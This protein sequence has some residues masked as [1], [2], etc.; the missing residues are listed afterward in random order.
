MKSIHLIEEK[1]I[2]RSSIKEDTWKKQKHCWVTRH[3]M[4][5]VR[6]FNA[7]PPDTYLILKITMVDESFFLSLSTADGWGFG[8]FLFVWMQ[9][10][11]GAGGV[12][13]SGK[14]SQPVGSAPPVSIQ[15]ECQA[16]RMWTNMDSPARWF[17]WHDK[18]YDGCKTWI[19]A[20]VSSLV[21]SPTATSEMAAKS[22]AGWHPTLTVTQVWSWHGWS[23]WSSAFISLLLQ[24]HTSLSCF[25]APW[26]SPEAACLAWRQGRGCMS[27]QKLHTQNLQCLPHCKASRNSR[28]P[29]TSPYNLDFR[30]KFKWGFAL[31]TVKYWWTCGAEN[32][33]K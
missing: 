7:G 17:V 15:L 18:D 10:P 31:V 22:K 30:S 29:S 24:P 1:Q 33:T 26:V 9:R 14:G 2:H 25:W 13:G 6:L 23:S 19:W 21:W 32:S 4:F 16:R 8:L 11:W 20:G 27:V 28:K 12:K 3:Q 5:Q